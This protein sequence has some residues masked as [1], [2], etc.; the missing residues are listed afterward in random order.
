MRTANMQIAQDLLASFPWNKGGTP[1]ARRAS[2]VT[3]TLPAVA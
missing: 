3:V 2:V 1:L